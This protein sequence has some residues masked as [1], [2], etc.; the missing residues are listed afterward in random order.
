M[1]NIHPVF[2]RIIPREAKEEKLNQKALVIWFTG[3]SGSGKT[4]M[5]CALEEELIKRGFTTQILDGDNIRAGL[6]SNLGFK[7]EDRIENIR[8]VAEV[9][10]LFLNCGII[11]LC[12]FVSPTED[13][14]NLV[15]SIVGKENYYEVFTNSALDVC[16]QRDVKGLYV[17]ARAG[18]IKDFTGIN[19]P[20][21]I[22]TT[23]DI[24]IDTSGKSKSE[25]LEILI[26][27]ILPKISR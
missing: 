4:T 5:A 7:N 11:T 25:N 12:A 27:T 26:N 24:T 19:A 17:K 22:P 13:L 1:N 18:E 15:K 21:D 3:L 2:D 6:N 9:A 23:P 10:K 16:E 14:R 20:F 8:R